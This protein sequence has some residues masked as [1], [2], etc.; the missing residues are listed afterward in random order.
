MIRQYLLGSVAAS[1]LTGSLP[2]PPSSISGLVTIQPIADLEA[3]L[4]SE[5]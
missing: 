5:T 1:S 3:G 4:Q 2:P